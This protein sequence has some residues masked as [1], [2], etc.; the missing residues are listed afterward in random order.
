MMPGKIQNATVSAERDD[1]REPEPPSTD[2]NRSRSRWQ[3]TRSRQ[4]ANA[5]AQK[6]LST[7][8]PGK[9]ED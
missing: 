3:L 6:K 1:G 2:P 4:F 9:A 8:N 5:A 7:A